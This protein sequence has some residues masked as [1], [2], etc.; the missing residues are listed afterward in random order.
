MNK[1][2]SSLEDLFKGQRRAR[3]ASNAEYAIV[4]GGPV[5]AIL[6]AVAARKASLIVIG[7]LGRRW[8]ARLFV[9]STT[10]G[11]LRATEIPHRH[12]A[13]V[14]GILAAFIVARYSKTLAF[15]ARS[16]TWSGA[17]FGRRSGDL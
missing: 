9:G 6:A 10:E 13:V 1:H 11:V 2:G 4:E 16:V 7:T 17:N 8:L 12:R 3:V 14:G 5:D 15:D